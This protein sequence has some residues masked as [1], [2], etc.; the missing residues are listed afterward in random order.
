[1]NSTACKKSKNN[2]NHNIMWLFQMTLN[3][4]YLIFCL[5]THLSFSN[6][7][8]FITIEAPTAKQYRVIDFDFHKYYK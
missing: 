8:L 1:M 2:N 6:Y 7:Y 4:L 3:S 5:F